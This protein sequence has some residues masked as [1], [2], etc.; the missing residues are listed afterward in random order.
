MVVGSMYHQ[1]VDA[2]VAGDGA[3]HFEHKFAHQTDGVG[4][5]DCYPTIAVINN[6][7]NRHQIIFNP[8]GGPLFLKARDPDGVEYT[9]AIEVGPFIY[10]RVKLGVIVHIDPLIDDFRGDRKLRESNLQLAG[11]ACRRTQ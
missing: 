1:I 11:I 10:I 7:R 3:T 5:D 9:V 4:G 8:L 2:P 6:N